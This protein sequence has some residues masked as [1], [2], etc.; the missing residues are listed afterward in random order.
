M[1]MDQV[2]SKT[3]KH[4]EMRFKQTEESEVVCDLKS[5]DC[6]PRDMVRNV[7]CGVQRLVGD[8]TIPLIHNLHGK[9]GE[10]RQEIQ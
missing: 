10:G 7:T 8:R 2:K 1:T 3:R 6:E 4:T 5:G 9:T